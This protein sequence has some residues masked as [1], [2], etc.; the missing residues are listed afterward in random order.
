MNVW[1]QLRRLLEE[2][3]TMLS[4][5]HAVTHD[6]LLRAIVDG[7]GDRK[8]HKPHHEQRSVVDAAANDFA[9]FLCN[10]SGHSVNGLEKCAESLREIR[11]S[12]PVSGAKQ[13]DHCFSN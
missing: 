13:H 7:E 3:A 10:D 2:A 9:H 5:V 1:T 11:N 6:E 4:D 12:D 8:Q